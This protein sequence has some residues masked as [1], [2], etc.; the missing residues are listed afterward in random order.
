MRAVLFAAVFVA[1][2]MG[3][4]FYGVVA[5]ANDPVADW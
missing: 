1:V 2:L 3:G 5:I 4:L